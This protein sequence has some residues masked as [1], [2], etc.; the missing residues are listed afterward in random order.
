MAARKAPRRVDG[1]HARLAV[2]GRVV[3]IYT[4]FA[5]EVGLEAQNPVE[6]ELAAAEP[7]FE[8]VSRVAEPAPLSRQLRKGLEPARK[9]RVLRRLEVQL[10]ELRRL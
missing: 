8:L 4:S 6:R 7:R 2:G 1:A 3:V 5:A 10:W 9:E